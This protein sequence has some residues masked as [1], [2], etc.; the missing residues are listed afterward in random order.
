MSLHSPHS[1]NCARKI[2]ALRAVSDMWEVITQIMPPQGI[3]QDDKVWLIKPGE[4]V[5]LIFGVKYRTLK[6]NPYHSLIPISR[7]TSA[8]ASSDRYRLHFLCLTNAAII[9]SKRES[10]KQSHLRYK[11]KLEK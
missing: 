10:A 2:V 4:T 11:D 5:T 1:S 3:L 6:E 9:L 7:T 8:I